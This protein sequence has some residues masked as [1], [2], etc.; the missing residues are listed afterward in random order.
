MVAGLAGHG[1]AQDLAV[2]WL[3]S[4]TGDGKRRQGGGVARIVF[5][6]AIVA[7]SAVT[8]FAQPPPTL[9]ERLSKRPFCTQLYSVACGPPSSPANSRMGHSSRFSSGT[10]P[11]WRG[12]G[13]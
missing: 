10:P 7:A 1:D 12:L 8:N 13:P 2:G 11:H 5:S 6:R 4:R 3:V 9:T